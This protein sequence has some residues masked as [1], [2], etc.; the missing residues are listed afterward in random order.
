[1]VVDLD[2]AAAAAG[3]EEHRSWCGVEIRQT[4]GEAIKAA[5]DNACIGINQAQLVG[6]AADIFPL[7]DIKCPI[8]CGGVVGGNQVRQAGVF[9]GQITAEI[10]NIEVGPLAGIKPKC[11]G[12]HNANEIAD[13]NDRVGGG[14]E[15][16]EAVVHRAIKAEGVELGCCELGVF[17]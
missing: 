16:P 2:A 13:I 5:L 4:Q 12:Q 10:D 8:A 7:G 9:Q 14:S 3:I 17:D 15:Q 6:L 11:I 1:M